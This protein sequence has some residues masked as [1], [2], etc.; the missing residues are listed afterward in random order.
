MIPPNQSRIASKKVGNPL[1]TCTDPMISYR[2]WLSI[3]CGTVSRHAPSSLRVRLRDKAPAVL[4]ALRD[5]P[6]HVVS[7]NDAC[8]CTTPR[9]VPSLR[10][11][12][13]SDTRNDVADDARER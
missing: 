9:E 6:S 3:P 8:A 13:C 12:R 7:G 11:A 5:G 1:Q 10:R 2:I 4:C